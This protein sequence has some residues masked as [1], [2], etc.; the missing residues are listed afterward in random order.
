MFWALKLPLNINRSDLLLDKLETGKEQD[1]YWRLK[2]DIFYAVLMHDNTTR[3]LT[4]F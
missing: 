3:F 1:Q 2:S 4:S